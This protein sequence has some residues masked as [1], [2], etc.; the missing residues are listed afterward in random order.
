MK[1]NYKSDFDFILVLRDG[2]GE[3]LMWPDY[4]WT[5]K[6]W[7]NQKVNA[8][9]ARCIDGVP[10]NCFN[11]GGRIHIVANNHHLGAG[12][13]KVEYH[14]ELD[15][16][17]YPDGDELV[18]APIDLDIE[19][20]R[21][22]VPY[23]TSAEVEAQLPYIKGDTGVGA[24]VTGYAEL[25]TDAGVYR[26]PVVM[27]PVEFVADMTEGYYYGHYGEDTFSIGEWEL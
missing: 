5:A 12:I 25:V 8:F 3:E 1:V 23:P 17:I 15:N 21:G 20:I 6:F 10:E 18:V 11:D 22:A 16:D 26:L 13:L 9:V 14:A 24:V 19:L 7:T 4:N 2:R 27:E